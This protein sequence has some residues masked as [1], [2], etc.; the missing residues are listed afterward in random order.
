MPA[1]GSCHYSTGA[2][3][4][5]LPDPRCTPG[6]I[7][8]A[9]KSSTLRS[10]V[11]RPGGYTVTIRPPQALTQPVK[12]KL[13]TAYGI[14]WSRASHYELDHLIELNAG[15]ASDT[16][17]LW[18]EPNEFRNGTTG[19]AFVHN[20]KDAIE[21]YTYHALC[22]GNVNLPAL[23]YAVATNWATSAAVLGLP[24]IPPGYRG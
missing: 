2:V 22:A 18:P 13:M 12:R 4:E 17:N 24:P 14:P 9:V 5:P 16:R 11:C 7:D 8:T 19:S 21:A 20:D 23:Q 10:T 3:G 1:A 15:G 6:A